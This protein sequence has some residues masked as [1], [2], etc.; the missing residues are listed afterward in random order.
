MT[1]RR[2]RITQIEIKRAVKA[3]T[4]CGVAVAEVI[5]QDGTVRVIA[6]GAPPGDDDED[7][8]RFR[9]AHGYQ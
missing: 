8:R 3:V 5:V 4:A 6:Q 2:A 7:T 9:A 1:A